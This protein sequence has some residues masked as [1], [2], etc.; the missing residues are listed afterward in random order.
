MLRLLVFVVLLLPAAAQTRR[1][2]AISHRGEH[3]HH[4]ENTIPAFQTAIDMGADFIEV[5]VRTTA[6]GKLILSHDGTVDRCTNAKGE[7]AKITFDELRALD[8]GVKTGPEF[9]GV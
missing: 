7:V 2:V 5:D 9:A 4:P 6:D 8:A 3:L 1:V